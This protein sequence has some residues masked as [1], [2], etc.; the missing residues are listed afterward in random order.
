MALNILKT[1]PQLFGGAFTALVYVAFGL[2]DLILSLAAFAIGIGEAN[3]V[4]AWLGQYGLFIPAKLFLTVLAGGL[5]ALLYQRRGIRPLA[6]AAIA[7]MAFVD[8][9][10]MWALNTLL[11]VGKY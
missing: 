5:I 1:R 9:Y 4:L 6:Y 11:S 2:A 7:I 8:A 10:H 3:P